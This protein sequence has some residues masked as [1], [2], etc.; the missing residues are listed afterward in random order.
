MEVSILQRVVAAAR[1]LGHNNN[2]IST[3]EGFKEKH[4]TV[5]TN[6]TWGA[7]VDWVMLVQL[8]EFIA[9]TRA[10]AA[11]GIASHGAGAVSD[12]QHPAYLES[13]AGGGGGGV[14]K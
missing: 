3:Q 12:V 6:R 4:V 7:H 2:S 9:S 11:L 8:C 13:L 10:L 14:W 5:S 1:A